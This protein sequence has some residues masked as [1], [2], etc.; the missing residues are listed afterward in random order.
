MVPLF[1]KQLGKEEY[2]QSLEKGAKLFHRWWDIPLERRL[3]IRK[4][5]AKAPNAEERKEEQQKDVLSDEIIW[6][7]P[8][9]DKCFRLDAGLAAQYL[10]DGN[11]AK[12]QQLYTEFLDLDENMALVYGNSALIQGKLDEA[13]SA[14]RQAIRL[15]SGPDARSKTGLALYFTDMGEWR[16]AEPLFEE[17]MNLNPGAAMTGSLWLDNA[18]AQN[19]DTLKKAYELNQKHPN[20]LNTYFLLIR[21]SKVHGN[22]PML[23]Q[24][25]KALDA[26][27]K[28]Q[29]PFMKD[30]LSYG[31]GPAVAYIRSLV[32]LERVEEAQELF[33]LYLKDLNSSSP[34][35]LAA[36]DIAAASGKIEA[37]ESLLRSAGMLNV[38]SPSYAL[39]LR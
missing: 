20:V 21:E 27:F 15:E 7:F 8:Q 11:H 25:F 14:Y 19:V 30:L 10:N 18:R 1:E 38:Y 35:L 29:E 16:F 12:V 31:E 3:D 32:Q 22:I 24:T 39:L 33:D 13:E 37:A 36:A 6:H 9:K 34:I 23:E 5:Q 4:E 17:V 26:K 2:M 28:E